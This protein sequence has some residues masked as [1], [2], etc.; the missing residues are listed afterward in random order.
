MMDRR[1]A[2]AS[3][4]PPLRWAASFPGEIAMAAGGR[5]VV[6]TL[7]AGDTPVIARFHAPSGGLLAGLR[8]ESA[9]IAALQRAQASR[10][11]SATALTAL[12]ASTVIAAAP[13]AHAWSTAATLR[14]AAARWWPAVAWLG[15]PSLILV[16]C[17]M[18]TAWGA[19]SQKMPPWT[20]AASVALITL[21]VRMLPWFVQ[22]ARVRLG[23]PSVQQDLH[24]AEHYVVD[25][26]GLICGATVIAMAVGGAAALDFAAVWALLTWSPPTPTSLLAIF[27]TSPPMADL[28][29]G[30]RLAC[31]LVPIVSGAIVWLGLALWL[32][33]GRWSVAHTRRLG[34]LHGVMAWARPVP[35]AAALAL[36]MAA[37]NALDLRIPSDVATQADRV[38]G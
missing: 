29:G 21:A 30:P 5:G 18:I 23:R 16:L 34:R 17:T 35:S 15:W 19:T 13:R 38:I 6:A 32:G 11:V 2:S 3:A 24:A 27:V 9:A 22:V 31:A 20:Y 25:S 10:D 1:G 36:A 4:S 14:R 7:G 12:T 33:S 28:S 8:C 26:A 37:A